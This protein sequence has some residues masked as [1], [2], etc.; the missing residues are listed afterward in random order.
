MQGKVD[1]ALEGVKREKQDF[2]FTTTCS[3]NIMIV[4]SSAAV[5]GECKCTTPN[6]KLDWCD[7]DGIFLH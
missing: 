3:S 2:G 1:A 5:L 4:W 7:L 6:S